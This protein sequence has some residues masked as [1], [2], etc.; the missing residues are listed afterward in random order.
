MGRACAL[1]VCL[2]VIILVGCAVK[3]P[4]RDQL[5]PRHPARWRVIG[6][7]TNAPLME[8][9]RQFGDEAL[10]GMV[11][12]ALA[13]NFDLKAAAARLEQARLRG[14][15]AGADRWPQVN[16]SLEGNKQRSNFIGLPLPG[17]G[18]V[19]RSRSESYQFSLATSW[20]LDLWGRIRAGRLAAAADTEAAA[21][22]WASA[23]QSLAAHTVK[24]WLALTEA[25]VQE[26]FARTNAII[27]QTTVRQ[28]RVRYELGIRPALDLRLAEANLATTEAVVE[29]W[30]AAREQ[31]R[32]QLELLLGRYPA[33]RVMARKDLPAMSA[34]IPVGLPSGLLTRRPD[35]VAARARLLAADA[36]K[37][38][39][40]AELYPKI[41][42]T[43][44][45]G[46]SSNELE[47]L[48][49]NNNLVWTLGANL[50]QP[51]F[52]GGRLRGN[53]KLA[54]ARAVEAVGQ[55]RGVVLNA[56]AEVE[57]ALAAEGVLE[58]RE[59]RLAVA[60]E[61][62]RQALRLAEDRYGRGV[63]PFVTVLDAQ[64]RVTETE[65]QRV[66]VR[67]QRLENRANLHLA[68]GGGFVEG[69]Q[70]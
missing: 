49:N 52:A 61:S 11:N 27:L 58:E 46:T 6:A 65:S 41:S 43:A 10:N 40:Q 2:P 26:D 54:H 12:E 63:E 68:L 55:Y 29:Q 70:Q 35:V 56:F 51:V 36:R 9:W 47:D 67:R 45:G 23:R 59:G 22:D 5:E 64:R 44:T 69:R 7:S 15:I 13:R 39:A 19:L 14:R 3:L 33:G 57:T 18:G 31:A 20:E 25:R 8:W 66:A 42:L 38:A 17:S 60:A 1:W 53:V 30:R 28:A 62:A 32:R 21:A 24:A 4:K 50:A 37:V 48:L 34:E 16:A